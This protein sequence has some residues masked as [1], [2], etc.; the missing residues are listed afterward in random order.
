ME[1]FDKKMIY[2]GLKKRFL[3]LP[4]GKYFCFYDGFGSQ[5]G[6]VRGYLPMED[7]KNASVVDVENN[8]GSLL[9]DMK[10]HSEKLK[11]LIGGGWLLTIK[12]TLDKFRGRIW[13]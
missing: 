11:G 4:N 7:Y 5:E 2:H 12:D 6:S 10:P 8:M 1:E 13:S 9:Q 3:K